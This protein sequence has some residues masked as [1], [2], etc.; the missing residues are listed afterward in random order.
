[1]NTK[2]KGLID[3]VIALARS[4]G[5]SQR[6]E[7][8]DGDVRMDLAR[9]MM[10][11]SASDGVIVPEE[12]ETIKDY[13][14]IDFTPEQVRDFLSKNNIYSA[15]F[16]HTVPESVKKLVALDN[17]LR[18]SE[19]P[20]EEDASEVLLA[21]YKEIGNEM[22]GSDGDV[23]IREETD[24]YI[25]LTTLDK[26]LADNLI[27]REKDREGKMAVTVPAPRKK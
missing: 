19:N 7:N 4:I 20:P 10:Y 9:F 15:A 1:M 11:L 8:Y 17:R 18:R 5:E 24:L 21:L 12:A 13:V 22:I 14:G 6:I 16:E 23:D 3:S 26:Y 27:S 2:L 25:Y